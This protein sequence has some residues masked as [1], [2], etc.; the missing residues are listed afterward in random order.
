MKRLSDEQRHAIGHA[1]EVLRLVAPDLQLHLRHCKSVGIEP[2]I[3]GFGSD[4]KVHFRVS[5][6][7]RRV[8]LNED[9]PIFQIPLLDEAT[10]LAH[11]LFNARLDSQLR[12][13]EENTKLR[14][15]ARSLR[16]PH[17][18]PSSLR[19]GHRL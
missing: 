12:T 17:T 1:I 9:P 16:S 14:N 18:Q 5:D 8:M 7:G 6:T 4:I 15:I 2:E 3:Y 11:K 19:K 10:L 13:G